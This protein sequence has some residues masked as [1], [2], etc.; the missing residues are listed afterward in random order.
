LARHSFSLALAV[1][2]GASP[3]FVGC[4]STGTNDV[5]GGDGGS[6]N[7]VADGS[8]PDAFA[9]GG[10]DGG[11][12]DGGGADSGDGGGDSA[13]A[14]AGPSCYGAGATQDG[15]RSCCE[16]KYPAG[17]NSFANL[18]IACACQGSLC[19][20]LEGGLPEGGT[21]DAGTDA[22]DDA[23]AGDGGIYGQA[24]CAATCNGTANP[25]AACNTCI[26]S[27]LGAVSALGPCGGTVVSACISDVDCTNYFGC[28]E[29]CP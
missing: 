5:T 1:V 2:L 10:G 26:Y 4:G 11:G 12:A 8:L 7:N 29:N 20:P 23:A 27:T 19:G 3:L 6:N 17:Y 24:V 15:C 22:G 25:S 21:S 9:G 18:T 28:V 13:A 14:D 16:T